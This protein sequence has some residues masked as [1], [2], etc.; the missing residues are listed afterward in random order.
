MAAI[1]EFDEFEYRRQLFHILLGVFIAALLV[2]DF[3]G[4]GLL[5][6]AAI[7]G[8]V[9]SYLSRKTRIPVVYN[10]LE[11]FERKKEIDD[12][13]GKGI[14]FYLI[15]AYIALLLFSKD[16]AMASIMV[17]AFGDSVSHLF[18]LR[19]CKIKH[20]FSKT[21]YLEGTLAGF[22]AGF[23]GALLFLPWHEAFFASL[24]AMIAESIEIKVGM[25]QVDDNLVIPFAAGAAVWIIRLFF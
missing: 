23:L 16:I 19:Y 2:Y 10:L 24:A 17:L 6:F 15:G 22:I 8:L 9:I 4:K 11:M 20:P 5:L 12:F 25:Q 13:P 21:K 7:F 14:I 18:G 1:S 3:I